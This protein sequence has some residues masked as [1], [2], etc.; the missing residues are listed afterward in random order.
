MG[1]IVVNMNALCSMRTKYRRGFASIPAL[2][3]MEQAANRPE[4][5]ID[6][7]LTITGGRAV[8]T[9]GA[10]VRCRRASVA[11]KPGFRVWI[12]T[13]VWDSPAGAFFVD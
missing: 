10:T 5:R 11:Q 3:A 13:G 9:G 6:I 7:G 2:T 12:P 8:G 4:D 1:F